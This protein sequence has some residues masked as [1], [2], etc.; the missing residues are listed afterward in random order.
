MN[1]APDGHAIRVTMSTSSVYP[2]GTEAAFET[3]ARLGYDGIEVMVLGDPLTQNHHLL[4]SW[5]ETYGMPILSVHAP[6]LLV[7]QRVWGTTDPWTKLDRSIELAHQVGA[8]AVVVHPPFR[9]QRDYAAGFADGIAEREDSTDMV[10]AVENMFPWR[11]RNTDVQAYLPDWDPVPQPY[12]HVT[13]DLSHTATAGSDALAMQEALGARLSHVHLAD[14]S[15]SF[16]DEHLVPGRGS[17]PCDEFL[18][19]LSETDFTGVVCLE[20]STRK[21]GPTAREADLMESL[22]YARLHLGHP[23]TPHIVHP[24]P[25]HQRL[26]TMRAGAARRRER[27]MDRLSRRATRRHL[28][29]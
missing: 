17:Q 15:G 6:C 28:R 13:L 21:L 10:L 29:G 20:V 3:A 4:R 16:K 11:A 14:G 5:S 27:R 18:A 26:T 25:H 2:L 8:E 23:P 24:H 22:A 19:R 12:D 7:T 1:S 9:W